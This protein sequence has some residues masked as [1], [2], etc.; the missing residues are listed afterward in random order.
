MLTLFVAAMDSTVVGTSLPTISRQLGDPALYPWVFSGYLLTSTTTVPLWGRM[1]DA[2]GRRR[3]L[4]LG[5]AI[6]V[7]ASVLC[8]IAPNMPALI[9]FRTLQGIGA[10]CVQPIVFTVVGDTF[11]IGQRARLQGV[12]S[13]V[14]AVA[15]VVGPALGAL[16]VSTIGWR[17]IFGI[18]LPIGIVATLLMWGYREQ[19][20]DGGDRRIEVVGALTLTAGVA[21]LLWGLGTGSATATPVWPA[22]AA[23]VVLLAVF[24]LWE[25]R[26]RSPTVPLDLL[27]HRVL[28]PAIT[29]S[30]LAGTIMFCVSAYVPLSVQNG[31]GQS[32]YLAGAAVAPMS[33]T[34]PLSSVLSGF[35]L[36]RFGFQPLAVAGSLALT[37]GCA[38]LGLLSTTPVL[39]G[40]GSAVVGAGMGMLSNPILVVIQS[41]VPWSKRGA[42]TAL[43]QFSRTIGGAVGVS[44]FGVLLEARSGTGATGQRLMAG[45]R[46][47]F[48]VCM[49]VA[50][51]MCALTVT[52]LL[53]RYRSADAVDAGRPGA[54]S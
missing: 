54:S 25:R 34:W 48:L 6:F 3:V 12:F 20:P 50:L 46:L 10:G 16:L 45:T 22:A 43:N 1:A 33:I 53:T 14:W 49:A 35:L 38:M 29:V 42:A 2:F 41:S 24:A 5:L 23:G 18:N 27:G 4:L 15:A 40:A 17:W 37:A 26:S 36:L 28:G 47:D 51:L 30:M 32:A 8:G 19:R 31:L 39:I 11:P 52:M 44:M 21:V 7:T 13:S 9:V